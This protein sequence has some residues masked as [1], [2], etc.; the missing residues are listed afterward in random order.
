MN[1]G[2]AYKFIIVVTFLSIII[3]SFLAGKYL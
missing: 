3:I 1:Y 2:E